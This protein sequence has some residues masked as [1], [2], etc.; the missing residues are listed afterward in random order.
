[1]SFQLFRVLFHVDK[2][3][4]FSRIVFEI[5]QRFSPVSEIIHTVFEAL[6]ANHSPGRFRLLTID[7]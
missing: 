1:M 5:D 7:R 4:G 2:I 6:A 3:N